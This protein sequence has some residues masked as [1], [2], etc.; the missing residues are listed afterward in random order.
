MS[1]LDELE[2]F[3]REVEMG[4][5]SKEQEIN[6]KPPENI[7]QLLRDV[8]NE[9]ADAQREVLQLRDENV[10]LKDRL[11]S[12]PGR[13]NESV[14]RDDEIAELHRVATGHEKYSIDLTRKLE[15]ARQEAAELKQELLLLPKRADAG[16]KG[17]AK[18][19]QL[20]MG[21]KTLSCELIGGETL[22]LSDTSQPGHTHVS[23]ISLA[24]INDVKLVTKPP[25]SFSVSTAGGAYIMTASTDAEAKSWVRA[26]QISMKVALATGVE[27]R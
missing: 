25:K 12:Q 20:M 13:G 10:T 21:A 24:H 16:P 3:L 6:E 14:D 11:N 9:L 22:E 7:V 2:A 18:R 27:L 15:E 8:N 5:S 19:G 1:D 4:G 17:P 23:K 26:C